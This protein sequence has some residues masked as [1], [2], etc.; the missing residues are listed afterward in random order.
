MGRQGAE[1]RHGAD[2][3]RRRRRRPLRRVPLPGGRLHCLHHGVYGGEEAVPALGGRGGRLRL[4]ESDGLRGGRAGGH[5]RRG[6]RRRAQLALGR[7]D[8]GLHE[9]AEAIRPLHRDREA[10]PVRGHQDGS[11]P[12]PQRPHDGGRPHR[13][14]H[15]EAAPAVPQ[16]P[17]GGLGGDAFAAEAA[18]EDLRHVGAA[19][20]AG[21][22]L[23]GRPHR[24]GAGGH[25]QRGHAGAAGPTHR[26]G[27]ARLR[28]RDPDLPGGLRRPRRFRR[29]RVRPQ[30]RGPVLRGPAGRRRGGGH[31]LA[32]RGRLGGGGAP[33]GPRRGAAQVGGAE[34]PGRVAPAARAL[35]GRG[36]GG[37][38]GRCA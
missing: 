20:G 5:G 25:R 22:L 10:R 12:L 16:A 32:S 38:G 7:R 11:R 19:A 36:G 23:Q 1:G 17:R 21:L 24:Q 15:A 30:V 8:L 18:Y 29:H 2:P 13:R 6:R 9:P 33:R 28:R 31:S 4:E 14:A 26:C 37:V 27:R 35:R 3:Q 34:E